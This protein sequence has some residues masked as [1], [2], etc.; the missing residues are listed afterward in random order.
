M[1]NHAI[2][3]LLIVFTHPVDCSAM[4]MLICAASAVCNLFLMLRELH[5]LLQQWCFKGYRM[6]CA[7]DMTVC[8][9]CY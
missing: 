5:A 7:H 3:G 6:Y 2:A 8:H 4:Y 1:R 9:L